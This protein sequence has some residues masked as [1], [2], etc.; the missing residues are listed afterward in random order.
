MQAGILL[1]GDR[2]VL[3]DDLLAT[4]GTAS[5]ALALARQIGADV[6]HAA[7]IIELGFLNGRS[8]LDI[9]VTSLVTYGE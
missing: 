3:C 4:G 5:A 7:F 1:P 2:A 6:I 9:P 8:R